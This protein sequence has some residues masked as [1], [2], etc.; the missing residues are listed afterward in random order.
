VLCVWLSRLLANIR[1]RAADG[2]D[3]VST[4]EFCE[5]DVSFAR[6][7]ARCHGICP[8]MLLV[9]WLQATKACHAVQRCMSSVWAPQ[10]VFLPFPCF[11]T[12]TPASWQAHLSIVSATESVQ[13]YTFSNVLQQHWDQLPSWCCC[14]VAVP[15]SAPVNC[16]DAWH[17]NRQ[18][19][20]LHIL[21]QACCFAIKAC[22]VA[23]AMLASS[24]H[25]HH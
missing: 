25:C 14:G 3:Q 6:A 20:A 22:A 10:V 4:L 2:Q 13:Q 19:H 17:R 15:C 16:A 8:D 5:G 24:Q 18:G 7:G 23:S 9:R 12:C 11:F 1:P 21:H